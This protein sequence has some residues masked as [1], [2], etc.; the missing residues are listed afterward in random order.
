MNTSLSSIVVVF[1]L[2]RS[3]TGDDAARLVV[4]DTENAEEPSRTIMIRTAFRMGT[5]REGVP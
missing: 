5:H 2:D 3:G 1:Q 4:P